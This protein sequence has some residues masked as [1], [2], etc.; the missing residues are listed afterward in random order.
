MGSNQ[1]NIT[2]NTQEINTN[3]I[4]QSKQEC[5]VS[6]ENRAENLSFIVKDSDVGNIS[7][8]QECKMSDNQCL[9]KSSFDTNM[10]SILDSMLQQS[11]SAPSGLALSFNNVGQKVSLNQLIENSVTQQQAAACS[12]TALNEVNNVFVYVENSTAQNLLVSQKGEV[13]NQ[14]CNMDIAATATVANQISSDVSQESKIKSLGT[15]L[16]IIIAI[17]IVMGAIVMAVMYAS[18]SPALTAAATPSQNTGQNTGQNSSN[19]TQ[20]GQTPSDDS[21]VGTLATAGGSVLTSAAKHPDQALAFA[22]EVGA[23]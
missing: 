23:L 16:M 17:A 6:C 14:M 5:I 2:R 18:Q 3:M 12:F 22:A 1:S 9:M 4:Q 7:I 21:F 10:A 19:I 11:A 8:V 20:G 13:N 15:E